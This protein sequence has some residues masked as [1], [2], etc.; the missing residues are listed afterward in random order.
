MFFFLI[1]YYKI[2]STVPYA[3]QKVLVVALRS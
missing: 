2:L 1:G 3:V